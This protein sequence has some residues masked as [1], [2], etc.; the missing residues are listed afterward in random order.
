MV[1]FSLTVCNAAGDGDQPPRDWL[2]GGNLQR[3]LGNSQMVAD[4]RVSDTII[5]DVTLCSMVLIG[6]VVMNRRINRINWSSVAETLEIKPPIS[7]AVHKQ[8]KILTQSEGATCPTQD[9]TMQH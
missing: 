2:E 9:A 6:C 1:S 4:R 3:S 5:G 8:K 7:V